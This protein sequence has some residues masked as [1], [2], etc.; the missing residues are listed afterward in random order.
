MANVKSLFLKDYT[1]TSWRKK[2][3]SHEV[4]NEGEWW[5]FFFNF[6][7]NLIAELMRPRPARYS[8]R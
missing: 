4:I 2:A 3:W 1:D 8:R 5:S 7:R 6:L